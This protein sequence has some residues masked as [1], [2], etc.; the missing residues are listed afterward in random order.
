MNVLLLE[1]D[2]EGL[3][4][5]IVYDA[6]NVPRIGEKVEIGEGLNHVADVINYPSQKRVD[7]TLRECEM[8]ECVS[9]HVAEKIEVIVYTR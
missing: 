8:L 9:R 6:D 2:A 5:E 4:G 1:R 7:S 3:Y